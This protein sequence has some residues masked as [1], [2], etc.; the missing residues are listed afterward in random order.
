MG[1]APRICVLVP[2]YNHGLT[3]G[4]VVRGAKKDFPVIAVNDGSTDQ[5]AAVL[6]VESGITNITFPQNQGK[7]AALKA[8]FA[9]AE[10]LGFTHAITIDADGQHPVAALR[11]FAA[12]S[13]KAPDAFI[14]GV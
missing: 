14:I 7:A 11:D 13:E 3:V 8:G 10:E 5:T 6:A 12:A 1:N 2:V 4:E 9:K